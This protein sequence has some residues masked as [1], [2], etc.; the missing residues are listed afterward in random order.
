MSE[1]AVQQMGYGTFVFRLGYWSVNH[2]KEPVKPIC[3][4]VK[5]ES[6]W[7]LTIKGNSKGKLNIP[8]KD[9][10]SMGNTSLIDNNFNHA[11]MLGE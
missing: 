1:T 10:A 4:S 2:T 8:K 3:E 7:E 5:D 11:L 6:Y 9:T